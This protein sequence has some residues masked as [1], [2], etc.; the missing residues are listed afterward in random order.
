MSEN[1][2]N[3]G[4]PENNRTSM[5]N[6]PANNNEKKTHKSGIDKLV[7]MPHV[8]MPVDRNLPWMRQPLRP[9]TKSRP[10]P[11]S[12]ERNQMKKKTSKLVDLTF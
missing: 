4:I 10:N 11:S 2:R 12:F 8:H 1:N 5:T 9:K 7:L 6:Q 3:Y